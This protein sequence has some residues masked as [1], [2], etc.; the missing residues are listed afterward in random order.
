MNILEIYQNYYQY[1]YNYALRLSCHPADACDITQETFLTAMEKMDTLQN[2]DAV[3]G[4]LRT[5]CYHRFVDQ[6]RKEKY[7]VETEDWEQLEQEGSLLVSQEV[8]PEEE[9]IV[10]EEIRALQNGCFLAMVRKLTLH[11]RIAFSLVDMYGMKTE[12]VAE[13]LQI[14]ENAAKGLLYRARMNI[15]SFFADHCDLIRESNPCSCKAW[16][17]FSQKRNAM[18]QNTKKLITKL[19]YQKSGYVFQ[20]NVRKKV[21]SLYRN[22]PDQKP[23][24]EWYQELFHILE[25]NIP[26]T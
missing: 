18:Q 23:S 10:A 22:M 2:S 6:T 14:S 16:I 8:Q 25:K 15:D 17:A 21:Y 26:E 12:H 9:V 19:D 24:E 7:L 13:L 5:I 1:I 3:A 20:E 4:W 11:Q